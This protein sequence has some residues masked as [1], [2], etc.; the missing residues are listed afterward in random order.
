MAQFGI[1]CGSKESKNNYIRAAE[2]LGI[3]WTGGWNEWEIEF[4]TDIDRDRVS[5]EVLHPT[6]LKPKL[7]FSIFQNGQF[8]KTIRVNDLG[9]LEETRRLAVHESGISNAEAFR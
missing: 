8:I 9:D 1:A 7:L 6:M 3:Y 4:N 2:K 5:Y